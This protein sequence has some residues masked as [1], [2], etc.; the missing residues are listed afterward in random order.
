[1][2]VSHRN[3]SDKSFKPSSYL[4]STHTFQRN[5]QKAILFVLI[6]PVLMAA[7]QLEDDFTSVPTNTTV[8]VLSE[9]TD[10]CQYDFK[11]VRLNKGCKVVLPPKCEKLTAI[12]VKTTV[13]E[14]HEMCCCNI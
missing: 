11:G 13:G 10:Q 5:M 3:S 4:Q 12:V 7:G 14:E 8:P 2:K 1:M 9:F 6:V